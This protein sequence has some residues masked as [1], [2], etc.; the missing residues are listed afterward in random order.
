[1]RNVKAVVRNVKAVVRGVGVVIGRS[2]TANPEPVV[3]VKWPPV[4][5]TRQLLKPEGQL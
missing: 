2:R 3:I 5:D 4:R 1:V